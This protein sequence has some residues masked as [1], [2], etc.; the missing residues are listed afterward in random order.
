MVLVDETFLTRRKHNRGGFQGRI[1]KGHTTVIFAAMEMSVMA[2]GSHKETGR[3]IL[4]VVPNKETETLAKI[5]KRYIK[6]GSDPEH[7]RFAICLRFPKSR[8]ALAKLRL[9]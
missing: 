7:L 4:K 2:D 5:M 1:T 3:A 6:P 8:K 9:W